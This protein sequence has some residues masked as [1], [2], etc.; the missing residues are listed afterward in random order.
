MFT[1]NNGFN[2]VSLNTQK[3]QIVF[4]FCS[5]T[6]LCFFATEYFN[7]DR[8]VFWRRENKFIWEETMGG[9]GAKTPLFHS[10]EEYSR[11][12]SRRE[13]IFPDLTAFL[14]EK[15]YI[16]RSRNFRNW[17]KKITA[18]SVDLCYL[19][20]IA[21]PRD[22]GCA[23]R[24]C[25]SL[26]GG[27]LEKCLHILALSHPS[28]ILAPENVIPE[29]LSSTSSSPHAALMSRSLHICSFA[30]AFNFISFQSWWK[31]ILRV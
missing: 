18:L 14:G 8:V 20:Q 26:G 23:C 1:H 19:E 9:S 6:L 28:H 11:Q 30:R 29:S 24:A 22:C 13:Q 31:Y 10:K 12:R 2:S 4:W 21:S 15:E 27:D 7:V 25:A 16:I 17:R 3:L 5:H